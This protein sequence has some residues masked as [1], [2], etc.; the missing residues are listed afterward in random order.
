MKK[1]KLSKRLHQMAKWVEK[2]STIADIGTDHGYLP[3]YL[4]DQDIISRAILCDINAG[5]L[6]N[7]KSTFMGSEYIKD[8]A[9]RL[10]SGIEPLK[11][12]EVDYV[13]IAGMGGSL[14]KDILNK[15]LEKS[16]SFKGL[17]LQ[18]QTEQEILRQWLLENSFEI[19][20][21]FY[22]FEDQKFYEAMYVRSLKSDIEILPLLRVQNDL[23]KSFSVKDHSN[24]FEF[25]YRVHSESLKTYAD[26]LKFKRRKYE[27]I[28][29][30][31]KDIN[32]PRAKDCI[33]KMKTIELLLSALSM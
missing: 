29:S 4:F 9:F 25:G 6:E 7:A 16:H 19:V 13:V 33:E 21:D 11:S 8:A 23:T 3:Y 15:D 12:K 2:D 18:P 30:K 14:I 26:Y 22:A 31:I 1:H 20:Y 17:F 24:D 32:N 27:I 10:G 28:R 5:P